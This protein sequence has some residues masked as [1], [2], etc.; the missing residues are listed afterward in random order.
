MPAVTPETGAEPISSSFFCPTY[1]CLKNSDCNF[2]LSQ[3]LLCPF[4]FPRLRPI[5][6]PWE[7]RAKL[8]S[9]LWPSRLSAKLHGGWR[10]R[11]MSLFIKA[12][13]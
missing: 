1:F 9:S 12:S 10:S 3:F 2:L 11:L 7:N 4:T 13:D 6:P 5:M 8:C